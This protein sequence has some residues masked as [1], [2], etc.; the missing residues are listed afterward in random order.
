M[1]H[2]EPGAKLIYGHNAKSKEELE[3]WIKDGKW[4]KLLRYVPVK[5][6]D[7]LYVPSGTVH[8]LTKGI[9]VIETQ[10]SSDVT[11]RLYDWDRV[12]KK[13]V[14]RESCILSNLLILFKYH[15]K[16]RS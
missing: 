14:R 5:E 15:I 7:F 11:Y 12:D 9:M 2:A 8:A 13:L 6:G 16:T 10:Q 3:K 4:S 1:L